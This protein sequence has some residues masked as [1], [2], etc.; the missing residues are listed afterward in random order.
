MQTVASDKLTRRPLW[1]QRSEL[2]SKNRKRMSCS[3]AREE[4]RT[5]TL[6]FS[7]EMLGGASFAEKLVKM[8]EF[9]LVMSWYRVASYRKSTS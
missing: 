1:V 7:I 6:Y 2:F 8:G 3:D 4:S 5:W 9:L